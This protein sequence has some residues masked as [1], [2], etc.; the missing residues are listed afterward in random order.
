MQRT[1]RGVLSIMDTGNKNQIENRF[2]ANLP[3]SKQTTFGTKFPLII[4]SRSIRAQ[5]EFF[6]AAA[7]QI[8]DEYI[9]SLGCK[10]SD[11]ASSK[12]ESAV[13]KSDALLHTPIAFVYV[14]CVARNGL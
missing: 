6:T 7:V 12:K 9:N 10:P 3:P 1:L 13:F 11:F 8:A 14:I 5:L 2:W 4:L